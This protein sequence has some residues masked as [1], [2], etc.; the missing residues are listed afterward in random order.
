MKAY[1]IQVIVLSALV[2]TALALA[3]PVDQGAPGKFGPWPVTITG[4]PDASVF[5]QGTDGGYSVGTHLTAEA[6]V[7]QGTPG[8][9]A[10]GWFAK[11]VNALGDLL[12]IAG[13]PVVVSIENPDSGVLPQFEPTTAAGAQIGS[14]SAPVVV[15]GLDG[16]TPVE[17]RA[18]E[19]LP[20]QGVDG[21]FAV[22]IGPIP[23]GTAAIGTVGVTSIS[24]GDTNIGN[25]DIATIGAGDTNIGNVDLASSIP[26]GSNNIG[27]VDVASIASG[28][29][30]IGDV[31]IATIA[32]GDTNIGNVDVA[33]I[34]AGDT[35]IGNVDVATLPVGEAVADP[36]F[37]EL[38]DGSAAVGTDGNPLRTSPSSTAANQNVTV[39]SI[40]AG[41]TNIGNVDVATIAAGDTNIGNVDVA[42]LPALVAGT[43]NIGDVD[44]ATLPVGEAV[45][46]PAFVELSDGANPVGTAGNPIRSDPTGTTTQPVSD[47]SSSLTVDSTQLPAA[48]TVGGN[49]KVS[50]AEETAAVTVDDGAGSLTVDSTQLPAAL[51]GSGNLS[52][53]IAEALPAGTNNIGDVDVASLPA[54]AAGTNSIGTVKRNELGAT[55]TA[56]VSVDTSTA[57]GETA[58]L[59]ASTWYECTAGTDLWMRI[60]AAATTDGAAIHLM[61]GAVSRKFQRAGDNK[62][63]AILP[64]GASSVDE[65]LGC[66]VISA[67][68]Q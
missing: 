23:A 22:T 37:V 44:V 2:G 59:T 64:A 4:S 62:V 8:T 58:E 53:A 18:T 9:A 60:G 33:T 27:D 36:A 42:T 21:G 54:L 3:A 30:N 55:T 67:T 41:D 39:T 16:G 51:T 11:L 25:V 12:G 20:I 48:L 19:T 45:A 1:Q 46:D 31:D 10:S 47:A 52:A 49:L 6:T 68:E 32:A 66:C 40:T 14:A 65:G 5:I 28:T 7:K 63:H 26:A 15:V 17:V 43:A 50:I 56:C 35:N 61:R 34:A 29:N 57:D 24:A 38:S 13:N